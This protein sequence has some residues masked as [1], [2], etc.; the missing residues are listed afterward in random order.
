MSS[1]NSILRDA[2]GVFIEADQIPAY[3]LNEPA[4]HTLMGTFYSK[5]PA[6]CTIPNS[7]AELN[8][9]VE[10]KTYKFDRSMN[11]SAAAMGFS[12]QIG[13]RQLLFI[14]DFIRYQ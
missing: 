9:G 6:D 5:L 14:Q 3:I 12:G 1:T 7:I 10:F 2:P 13:K 4:E 11:T 8:S